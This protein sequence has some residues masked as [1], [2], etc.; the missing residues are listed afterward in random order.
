MYLNVQMSQ[1]AGAVTDPFLQTPSAMQS[2]QR[3]LRGCRS[4]FHLLSTSLKEGK[5]S[6]TSPGG[7]QCLQ[8]RF[9]QLPLRYQL[10]AGPNAKALQGELML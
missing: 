6:L 8:G 7:Q 3:A 5:S 9:K 4:S 2:T 10:Q 1:S